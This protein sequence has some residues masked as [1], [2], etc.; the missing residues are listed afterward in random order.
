MP[1]SSPPAALSARLARQALRVAAE[2]GVPV[3]ALCCEAGL[4]LA[5]LDD[6]EL[7]IPYT[8]LDPYPVLDALFE[9]AVARS[10]MSTS[11]CTWRGCRWWTR[12]MRPRWSSFGC[13][14]RLDAPCA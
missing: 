9:R 7:R 2:H 13:K 14:F 6:P 11:G 8:V 4:S 10:G 1:S 12:T 3:E 5:E